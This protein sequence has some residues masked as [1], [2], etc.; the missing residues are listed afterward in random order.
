MHKLTYQAPLRDMNFL[1]WEQFRIQDTLGFSSPE[2][3]EFITLNLQQA[4][5]FSE[6]P[7]ARSYRES[8]EQEAFLTKAGTVQL[9]DSYPVL[10]VAYREIWA[11]WM[12]AAANELMPPP[13]LQNMMVEMFMSGNA[14]FMTYV[15]FSQPGLSLLGAHG[16]AELNALYCPALEDLNATACLC[17][18]ELEAGSDLTRLRTL[19]LRQEDGS[20]RMSGHKWL[21]S[22]G[23]HELTDNIYYFVLCRTDPALTGMVGLSCFLVP[24][25]RFDADGCPSVDNG[26]RVREVVQKMGFKGC[27][28]TLITFSEEVPTE[29]Y[30]LGEVEGRGLQQLM[31]MM[32]PARISTG[33]FALGLASSAYETAYAYSLQ[34]VQGKRFDQSMSARAPSLLIA[35]HP[36]VRRMRLEMAAYTTGCR[37]LLARLGYCQSIENDPQATVEARR[38]AIDISEVLLPLVKAYNSDSAWR[39]CETAIQTMGGVGFT[40][41]YPAQQNA[42]DC[43][44]LSIWEGTNHIQALFLLRDKLGMC[45]RL[46]RLEVLLAEI[47]SVVVRAESDGRFARQVTVVRDACETVMAAAQAIGQ[48]VRIQMNDV[49]EFA[50]E[51]QSSLGDLVIAWHL[52]EAGVIARKALDADNVAAEDAEFYAFKVETASFFVR[53]LLPRGIATARAIAAEL[54]HAPES[55][56]AGSAQTA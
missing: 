19:A 37:A 6:G 9:P 55:L 46:Q 21:I 26:I 8:D 4:Q 40:R 51:F 54:Q 38:A 24:R 45:M 29:G 33:I 52:L 53:R 15:G 32:K 22:A 41:D 48:R 23:S 2:S 31:M 3:H 25:Y 42:R 47:E 56:M 1:L 16:S 36:D 49:S 34:R 28:N 35:E 13:I 12:N 18:T 10:M 27:A 7:L 39:V 43:K 30:L 5:A 14:S 44:V 11:R 17:I 50:V 20:Y